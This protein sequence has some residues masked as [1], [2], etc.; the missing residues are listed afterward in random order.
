[1]NQLPNPIPSQ[2]I[3]LSDV[4]ERFK[5]WSDVVEF[6]ATFRPQDEMPEGSRVR[7]LA[8]ITESSKISDIRAALFAEW[9][10][11]NHFGYGPEDQVFNKAKRAIEL[12]RRKIKSEQGSRGNG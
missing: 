11:Y 8:D 6:A 3:Q 9:R 7:G 12:L 1:M 2:A 10:R 5:S 4:P